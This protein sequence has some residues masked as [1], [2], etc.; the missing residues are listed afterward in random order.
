MIAIEGMDYFVFLAF[1]LRIGQHANCLFRRKRWPKLPRL[2]GGYLEWV[3][4]WS[5][6]RSQVL[7]ILW[8]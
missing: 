6:W 1:Y 2:C 3:G 5:R 7:E 4:G 8:E